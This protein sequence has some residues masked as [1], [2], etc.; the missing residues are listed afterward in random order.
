MTERE[1]LEGLGLDAA[2]QARGGGQAAEVTRPQAL[3]AL[4][5]GSADPT[6]GGTGD[7]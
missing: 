2:D 1:S 4:R 7:R 6:E 5:V 3:E